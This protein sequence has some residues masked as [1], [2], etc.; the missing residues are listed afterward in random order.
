MA[1]PTT[2]QILNIIDTAI[3]EIARGLASQRTIDLGGGKQHTY[4]S[5]NLNELR[6][7]RRDYEIRLANENDTTG[8]GG[9]FVNAV[10]TP[11]GDWS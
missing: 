9:L 3:Y 10:F 2:Q 8:N 7:L 6:I 5:L 11:Y 4:T 1:T